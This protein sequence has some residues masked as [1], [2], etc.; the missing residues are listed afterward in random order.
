MRKKILFALLSLLLLPLG[1]M[2]QNVTV[3]SN[4]GNTIAAEKGAGDEDNFFSMG[5]FALW[6]HNQLN[7]NMTTSDKD[8]GFKVSDI[9]QFENPANNIFKSSG[10]AL[11]LGRGN[12]SD[13]YVAFTLPK[14]Y[15]FTGYTIVFRRNVDLGEGGSG[16]NATFGEVVRGGNGT[17]SWNW[18]NDETHVGGM[19]YSSSAARNTI[20]RTSMTDTDMDNTL[21]FKLTNSARAF[22]T[23]E[24]VELFFTAEADYTPFTPAGSFLKKHAVDVPFSTSTVDI[25]V[26]E[27]REYNNDTR[28]S[29]SYENVKDVMANLTLFEAEAVKG[30]TNYDG[31]SGTVVDPAGG[32]NSSIDGTITSNGDYFQI[33]SDDDDWHYYYIETPTYIELKNGSGTKNPIGYRITGAKI[34]YT[35]GESKSAHTETVSETVQ[36]GT[37]T[38]PTFTISQNLDTYDFAFHDDTSWWNDD[39][40]Y[41]TGTHSVK[42][43]YLTSTGEASSDQTK[44]ASWFI[45]DDGY[46]RLAA[47]P[48]KYLKQDSYNVITVVSLA[49]SPAKY[50][51]NE[52]GQISIPSN[53]NMVI[54]LNPVNSTYY[55]NENSNRRDTH[56]SGGRYILT[57]KNSLG[58]NVIAPRTLTGYT[59]TL[60]I[61]TTTQSTVSFPAFSPS[62]F[63]LKV[64]D[65]TG[66]KVAVYGDNGDQ[67]W[68]N[69][70]DD[71]YIEVDGDSEDGIV[72]GFVEIAGMN[73]DAVKI[74]VKGVG[75]IKGDIT[76]QAL[77]PY[78]NRIEIVC[79]EASKNSSNEYVPISN[80]N[81]LIQTF[82]ASDFSVGG[83]A[84]HFYVPEG[85][86]NDCLFTF[87]NLYS[88]Y[89]DNTYYNNTTSKNNARYSFVKSPYWDSSQ[90]LYNTTGEESYTTKV[91]TSVKGNYAYRFNN[92]AEVGAGGGTVE[93]YPFSLALYGAAHPGEAL[94]SQLSYTNSEMTVSTTNPA[95]QKIAYLFTCD[96]TRYNIST[97]TATQHRTYAFYKMDITAQKE[98]FTPVFE[99]SKIYNSSFYLDGDEE[100]T[101]PLYGLKLKTTTYSND[102][103][104]QYGYLTVSQIVNGI[105]AG[106]TTTGNLTNHTGERPTAK[107]QILYVDA[108]ELLSV[109][110][111]SETTG[112]GAN[113]TTNIHH[114]S[115]ILNGAGQNDKPIGANAFVF[116]PKQN[117][118]NSI[119]NFAYKGD[120][121]TFTASNNIELQD[122]KPFFALYDISVQEGNY[123]IYTRNITDSRYKKDG[124]ASIMLPFSLSLTGGKH[125]NDD[126]SCAFTVNQLNK[127]DDQTTA[128][129]GS[130]N[131]ADDYYGTA[132]FKPLGTE[133]TVA[134]KPYMIKVDGENVPA[135]QNISFIAKQKGATIK[136]TP[137]TDADVITGTNFTGQF[138]KGDAINVSFNNST[139]PFTNYG[140][141]S[142]TNY[143]RTDERVFYF[144][145]N[146]YHNLSDLLKKYNLLVFPFRG[147]YKYPTNT[148][149]EF[150]LKYFDISFDE[151]EYDV[152]GI[153]DNWKSEADLMVRTDKGS[154]TLTATKAQE[155]S[156]Y[157]ANGTLAA[158][159]NMQGG[160]T[161]TVSLPSGL[162]VVNNVKIGV[163]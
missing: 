25:G 34:N 42:T 156:I 150:S 103:E 120:G 38:Y 79:Q 60:N 101:G 155:V 36:T 126:G 67:V 62:T 157:A 141:F 59:K 46:I 18:Y 113:A 23:L 147:I 24:S 17:A 57:N 133:T 151:P 43:F 139:V 83:D 99:W 55:R 82:T 132:Y 159:V 88:T 15:R 71:Q 136:A 77:D 138:I 66:T 76:M 63:Q 10:N 49:E 11:I 105:N 5:G 12:L 144:A 161:Q 45:D 125:T 39:Y 64:F 26:V 123:A 84:F 27:P 9:G 3:R 33:G 93:E 162:Y 70:A 160:D 52:S 74:G 108:S 154:M 94:F 115:E 109:S 122:K 30:G 140:T 31:I 53:A 61:Y 6:K 92:A 142:G 35:Y 111:N 143:D 51:I 44:K 117:S 112:T 134:N 2:A 48:D 85:W 127:K 153:D 75:L 87:E 81:R 146:M 65:K 116:L 135:D 158:K 20:K 148:S 14:G 98:T 124:L 69:D 80:G 152:T 89:G 106:A 96:E 16:N 90:N 95:T 78:I 102:A 86:T 37:K 110:E 118:T 32:T 107:S 40:Y 13:S 149:R 1:V 97:A 8:S 21:Y 19:S 119:G 100:K 137:T 163:K 131:A 29:Y 41:W 22:I 91:I 114:F 50:V 58:N 47:N 129:I 130:K 28:V 145:N 68:V 56:V 104:Q 128:V 4:N 54:C 72:E 121:D 7:L 73:N